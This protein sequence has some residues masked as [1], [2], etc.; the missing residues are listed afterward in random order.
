MR[1][2]DLHIHTTFSDGELAARDAVRTVR[3]RHHSVGV[4]DHLSPY[5]IMWDEISFRNYLQAL[6]R[7][8][9]WKSAELCT[10]HVPQ[11]DLR[12]LE[13][14]DYIITG[15]HA[16]R[17]ADGKSLFLWDSRIKPQDPNLIAEA[18]LAAVKDF[19]ER[20][21]F[22]ILAHPTYLPRNICAPY[23]NPWT[24]EKLERLVKL[25]L[26]Y[27]FA[28]ELSGHWKVPGEILIRIGREAGVQFSTGSDGH[29]E[30]MLADLRY[31]QECIAK[32]GI[33]EA[34]LFIPARKL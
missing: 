16:L 27:G 32:Y 31:P 13:E 33:T 26:E 11:F 14:L 30:A 25:C 1:L 8:K 3:R 17:F 20:L 6:D 29:S 19:A 23:Q 24:E 12:L 22:D 2:P 18:Y 34:E 10:G 9:C 15:V 28:L 21:H 5:H 7:L 4:A